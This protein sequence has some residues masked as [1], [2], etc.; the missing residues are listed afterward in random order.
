[1]TEK[2]AGKLPEFRLPSE[3]DGQN[4]GG[5]SL[6]IKD[7]HYKA[8]DL[9]ELRKIAEQD[10]ALAKQIVE[11]RDGMHRRE[12]NS[13]LVGMVLASVVAISLIGGSVTALV[14]LGWWQAIVF[15]SGLMFASHF[16]RVLMTG[17]WS[18]TSWIGKLFKVTPPSDQ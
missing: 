8:N 1:M 4:G 9:T 14:L 13:T 12:N 17:Q 10:P 18:E 15:A 3:G 7:F 11:T 5:F 6:F 2:Q 16:L